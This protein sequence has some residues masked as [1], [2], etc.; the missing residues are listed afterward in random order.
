MYV[1]VQT[2]ISDPS[3][4]LSFSLELLPDVL[5][6]CLWSKLPWRLVFLRLE[7]LGRESGHRLCLFVLFCKAFFF[8]KLSFL[9]STSIQLFARKSAS[10]IVSGLWSIRSS[11]NLES[12]HK[13]FRRA[14]KA[15]CCKILGSFESTPLNLV[16]KI[17]SD[18]FGP[19]DRF[20]R[21][22]SEMLL[23]I[24]MEYCFKKHGW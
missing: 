2:F 24:R 11:L 10:W 12:C 16:I 8:V 23:S 15:D 4:W 20:Q 18:S 14:D 19:W 7:F 13:P 1:T 6:E 3:V 17:L 9:S 21:S 22:M 5:V